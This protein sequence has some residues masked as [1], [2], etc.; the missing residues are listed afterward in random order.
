M[1]STLKEKIMRN[2]RNAELYRTDKF[3]LTDY[4]IAS[5]EKEQVIAYRQELRDL[6]AKEG[7]PN[8]DF[9]EAPS[10]TLEEG[11]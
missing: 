3:L 11:V 7:F 1:D 10:C 2:R 9:P 4:P 8:V 6:P 5:S